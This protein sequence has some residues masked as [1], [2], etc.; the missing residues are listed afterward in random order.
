MTVS[1][2]PPRP[3]LDPQL[4]GP[5][6]VDLRRPAAPDGPPVDPGGRDQDHLRGQPATLEEVTTPGKAKKGTSSTTP[7][8]RPE[9]GVKWRGGAPPPPPKWTYEKEDL[10]AFSKYERK[11]RL[12]EAQVEPYM[13][14]REASLQLYNALSGEPEQESGVGARSTRED[15]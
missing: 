9:R 3:R 12:W 11:V 4:P 1:S 7:S 2:R 6:L 15:K 8:W 13:S 10:P 14:K 5:G